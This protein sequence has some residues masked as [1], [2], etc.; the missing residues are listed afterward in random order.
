M[1]EI[2]SAPCFYANTPIA[3]AGIAKRQS[4]KIDIRDGHGHLVAVQ[5]CADPELARVGEPP[6]LGEVRARAAYF[7]RHGASLAAD[8]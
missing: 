2:I 1:D 3:R 4:E 6:C 7:P 5:L 8:G